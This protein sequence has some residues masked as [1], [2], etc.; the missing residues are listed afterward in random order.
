MHTNI[1]LIISK[2][3]ST[4]PPSPSVQVPLTLSLVG[5]GVRDVLHTEHVRRYMLHLHARRVRQH[6]EVLYHCLFNALQIS[7]RVLILNLG[8]DIGVQSEIRSKIFKVFC[9]Q[10]CRNVVG[11]S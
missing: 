10:E 3:W 7:A 6:T 4:V 9:M 8:T 1:K 2:H 5:I 11:I